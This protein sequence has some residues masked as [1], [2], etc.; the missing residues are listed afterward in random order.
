[1]LLWATFACSGPPGAGRKLGDDLGT[2]HVV[3][4]ETQNSCGPGSLG[5]SE[6][7]EFDIELSRHAS[8]L[9]WDGQVG[10]T[11]LA[12]LDFELAAEVSV[13]LRAA[14]AGNGGCAIDRADRVEGVLTEDASGDLIGFTGSL[15]YG[16]AAD[17]SSECSL[18]DELDSG[19]SRLPCSMRYA[20]SAARTRTPE[21][22]P[23]RPAEVDSSREFLR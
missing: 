14:R 2:F 8:E 20:L 11:I 19:L 17:P 6:T 23:A 22:S 1:L 13:T 9:F 4:T 16:F 15:R 3:A 18:E 5:S 21:V 12:S 10:G 7:F